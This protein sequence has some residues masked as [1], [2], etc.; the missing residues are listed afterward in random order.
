[1]TDTTIRLSHDNTALAHLKL[2]KRDVASGEAILGRASELHQRVSEFYRSATEHMSK[3]QRKGASQR[4]IA[5]YLGKSSA[6]VNRLLRWRKSG[7]KDTPF[8]PESKASRERAR[9]QAAERFGKTDKPCGEI[10][11]DELVAVSA[12]ANA[13]L[14]ERAKAG[15][16]AERATDFVKWDDTPAVDTIEE[17]ETAR[18]FSGGERARLIEALECLGAKRSGLRAKFALNVE[19][20]RAGL[21]LA[22]DQLL[23]PAHEVETSAT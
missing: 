1:M 13:D 5:S 16:K 4:H 10:K 9:V 7:Y 12:R 17:R 18:T 22:W 15:T 20:R 2:A 21:G 23:I 11:L 8:G 19:R 14:T 6:W 3:A